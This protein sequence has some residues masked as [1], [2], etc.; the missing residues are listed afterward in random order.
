MTGAE[1]PPSFLSSLTAIFCT[2]LCFPPGDGGK[3]GADRDAQ[4]PGETT[5][6]R[7]NDRFRRLLGSRKRP[8]DDV[9]PLA[10]RMPS[11]NGYWA[12]P[13]LTTMAR[14]AILYRR[15]IAPGRRSLQL[16]ACAVGAVLTGREARGCEKAR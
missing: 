6:C 14:C 2:W 12:L 8:Q 13:P 4:K 15:T 16:A 10:G 3:P 11:G 1:S 7:D 5:H 9:F